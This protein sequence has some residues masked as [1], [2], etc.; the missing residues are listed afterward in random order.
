[1]MFIIPIILSYLALPTHSFISPSPHSL[2]PRQ[3][4]F[5]ARD[6][7]E[8]RF[9][10]IEAEVGFA[11]IKNACA[12]VHTQPQRLASSMQRLNDLF[13]QSSPNLSA[14]TTMTDSDCSSLNVQVQQL[15]RT[16]KSTQLDLQ[17]VRNKLNAQQCLDT[18]EELHNLPTN[19]I[20]YL[21]HVRQHTTNI[22]ECRCQIA[23]SESYMLDYLREATESFKSCSS[24]A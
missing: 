19:L 23:V 12:F 20:G 1:M 9:M 13:R 16:V 18:H 15:Q 8:A 3:S 2:A 5:E 14:M 17:A 24:S 6:A 10:I 7:S 11:Y 4:S 21:E 22:G